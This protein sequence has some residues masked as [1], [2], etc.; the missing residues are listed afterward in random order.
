MPH[1]F[2]KRFTSVE[3]R[4]LHRVQQHPLIGTATALL[5]GQL[6]AQQSRCVLASGEG[7]LPAPMARKNVALDRPRRRPTT[8]PILKICTSIRMAV[9]DAA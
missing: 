6:R 1:A 4:G 9:G 3:Q 5:K 8:M 2:P 7:D